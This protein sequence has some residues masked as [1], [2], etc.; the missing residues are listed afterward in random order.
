ML[1]LGSVHITK[2]LEIQLHKIKSS[3]ARVVYSRVVYN[4]K[5]CKKGNT[6][7]TAPRITAWSPTVVLTER[8]SG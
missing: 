3:I 7:T 1:G 4:V 6:K 2:S 5:T 8:H